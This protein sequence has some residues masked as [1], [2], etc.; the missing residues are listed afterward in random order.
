MCGLIFFGGY[1]DFLYVYFFC[2]ILGFWGVF[3]G[4]FWGLK[5]GLFW[6]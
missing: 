3:S 2:F 4:V 6:V 5:R 1:G